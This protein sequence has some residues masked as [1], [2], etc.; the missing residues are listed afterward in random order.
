MRP[1]FKEV[2]ARL[3]RPAV[4]AVFAGAASN[5]DV[6][7]VEHWMQTVDEDAK[8][9]EGLRALLESCNLASERVLFL[10]SRNMLHADSKCRGSGPTERDLTACFIEIS[11]MVPLDLPNVVPWRLPLACSQTKGPHSGQARLGERMVFRA[12]Y[13]LS[14]R[15]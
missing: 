2:V 6:P 12:G 14:G 3:R 5:D 1:A 15:T 8:S 9:C 10:T 4:G 13:R 7:E 11:P